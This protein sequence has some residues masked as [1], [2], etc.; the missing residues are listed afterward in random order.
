MADKQLETEKQ[1]RTML[2]WV[3]DERRKGHA[4]ARNCHSVLDIGQLLP[5]VNNGLSYL[6]G[7]FNGF[8]IGLVISLGNNQINQLGRQIYIGVF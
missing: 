4:V 1:G 5:Q 8:S 6:I 3:D 2:F 7:G